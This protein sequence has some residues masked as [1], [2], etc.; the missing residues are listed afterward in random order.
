[1]LSLGS[2]V[3]VIVLLTVAAGVGFYVNSRLPEKHRSKDTIELVGLAI[4][5]LVT[6][7]AIVLGLLT[8]SVKTGF[9]FGVCGA[10]RL[11]GRAHAARPLP[12]R[13]RT[14]D[15]ADP[16]RSSRICG[17]DHR[18]HVA[19]R[20]CAVRR[21]L[22]RRLQYPA[23]GREPCPRRHLRSHR[24]RHQVAAGRATNFNATR[25]PPVGR[26]MR[27]RFKTAGS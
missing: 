2:L 9:D 1:M 24:P 5:L 11:C 19:Q 22:S 17:G 26:N 25:P 4:S 13:F 16:R 3:L 8:T 7:T 6:F 18:Q 23:N 20:G 14:R 10:R 12:R 21:Q 27:A 15:R